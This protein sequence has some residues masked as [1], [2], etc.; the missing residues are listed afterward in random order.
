MKQNPTNAELIERSLTVVES[1]AIDG[2]ETVRRIQQFARLRP[3]EQFMRVDIN[4]IVQDAVAM[5]RPRWEE[6][7]ARDRRPLTCA[8]I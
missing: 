7:I 5:T 1:A 3:E 4:H 2:S 8:W 6:Q